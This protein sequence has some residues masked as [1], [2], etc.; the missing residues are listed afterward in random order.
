MFTGPLKAFFFFYLIHIN[1]IPGSVKQY[2]AKLSIDANLGIQCSRCA[3]LPNVSIIHAHILKF[4]QQNHHAHSIISA[5]NNHTEIFSKEY[6]ACDLEFYWN[7]IT[8]SFF[9][10][11]T[12]NKHT[13]VLILNQH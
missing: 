12:N 2:D 5:S 11:H 6:L 13:L 1:C 8:C 3:S 4:K 9:L 10:I 7:H